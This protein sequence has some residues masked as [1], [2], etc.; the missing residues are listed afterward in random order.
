MTPN[1]GLVLTGT[2]SLKSEVA[3][4]VAATPPVA[5]GVGDASS[6]EPA[7]KPNRAPVFFARRGR[8]AHVLRRGV[9]A[10]R[11]GNG[12]VPV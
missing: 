6:P 3:E 11:C 10:T 12:I 9:A 1:R 7:V 4:R 2:M 5:E 8:R